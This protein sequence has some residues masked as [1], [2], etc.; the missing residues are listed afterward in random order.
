MYTTYHFQSASEINS[1]ILEAIKIAFKGKSVVITVEEE[2]QGGVSD[3]P[4]W[5]KEIVRHRR[6]FYK[7]NPDYGYCG[8]V[9]D[10]KLAKLRALHSDKLKSPSF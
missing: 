10:P 8:F 3:I 2:Q 1:D 9:I 4:E 5:Q 7:N 6:D